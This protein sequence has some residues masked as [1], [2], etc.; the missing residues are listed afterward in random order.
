MN[1]SELVNFLLEDPDLSWVMTGHC[2]EILLKV[3]DDFFDKYQSERSKREDILKQCKD[4][5]CIKPATHGDFCLS[6]IYKDDAVL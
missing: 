2:E 6:H 4:I 1:K 5:N 3:I